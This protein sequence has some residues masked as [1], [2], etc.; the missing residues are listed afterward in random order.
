[1]GEM[2]RPERA[3]H[4]KLAEALRLWSTSI[5]AEFGRY[6][7]SPQR[8]GYI[9]DD[10]CR[11]DMR[12]FMTK[13]G[14]PYQKEGKD[15]ARGSVSDDEMIVRGNELSW[16]GALEEPTRK[17]Y[18]TDDPGEIIRRWGEGERK[19]D[20]SLAEAAILCILNRF[21]GERFVAV[22]SAKYDDYENGVDTLILDKERGGV[23]CAFDEVVGSEGSERYENKIRRA[24]GK[25]A[26]HGGMRVK[27]GLVFERD[28]SSAVRL[29]RK[30]LPNIP[31]FCI[32]LSHDDLHQ[33]VRESDFSEG[34]KPSGRESGFFRNLVRALRSQESAMK[35]KMTSEQRA[36]VDELIAF[37]ESVV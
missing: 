36:H 28:A 5:N 21:L 4:E 34:G 27:Y 20:G 35:E 33:L 24:K 17:R 1:M 37:A 13:R 7:E 3:P 8:A 11:I 6:L 12:A 19:H 32:S 10:E 31:G 15:G 23:V 9:L 26:E 22:R 16:S 29:K 18:G 30:S 14:G 2:R 25:L